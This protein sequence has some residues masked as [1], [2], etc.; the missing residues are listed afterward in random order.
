[1]IYIFIF[2][3][4]L[5]KIRSNKTANINEKKAFIKSS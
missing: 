2:V 4:L 1:M 3:S 5:L